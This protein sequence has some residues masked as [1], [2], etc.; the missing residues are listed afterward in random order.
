[1]FTPF[2]FWPWFAGLLFLAA[3]LIAIRKEWFAAGGLDKIVVL[4]RVFYAVPLAM[5]GAEHLAGPRILAQLVPAWIPARLF[6]AYFVGFALLAAAISLILSK[7][8]Q[9]SLTLLGIMFFLFVILVHLPRV[10]ANPNDRISWAVVL[11]DLAFAGGAWALAGSQLRKD[12]PRESKW[13]IVIGRLTIAIALLFFASEHFLHP[14]SAPGVPLEKVT[15]AWIPFA[16]LWGYLTGAVL[17]VAGVAILLDKRTRIAAAW[18]GLMMLLLTL[19]I[20]TP[21]FARAA[22]PSE[23]IE[24]VN[25]VADTLFFGGTVLLLALSCR[26]VSAI[27]E[28][29]PGPPVH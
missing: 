20:Y 26:K 1:M 16:P 19:I 10:A 3:G 4:G 11:R 14:A 22:K 24:G 6:W 29:N 9:L 5:F 8:E 28:I 17:L 18:V 23:M 21:I 12:R 15:P 13:M 2:I 27:P 7:Y 25:Y